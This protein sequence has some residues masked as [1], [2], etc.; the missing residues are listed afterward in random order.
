MAEGILIAIAVKVGVLPLAAWIACL[1]A[2]VGTAYFVHVFDL[3]E[4]I[5]IIAGA[6]LLLVGG[7]IVRYVSWR[8]QELP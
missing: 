4:A 6:T 7:H 2:A 1:L 5:V 3:A 8:R